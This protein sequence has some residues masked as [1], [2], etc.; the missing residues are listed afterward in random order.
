M[1]NQESATAAA[2]G[3]AA[4]HMWPVP[5]TNSRKITGGDHEASIS[6]FTIFKKARLV[7]PK[8][9][10]KFIMQLKS[11]CTSCG[12]AALTKAYTCGISKCSTR[13][14][15][16]DLCFE[17]YVRGVSGGGGIRGC[18]ARHASLLAWFRDP[19]PVSSSGSLP[20]SRQ[21]ADIS[22]WHGGTPVGNYAAD[23]PAIARGET[24]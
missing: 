15:R 21:R 18:Q 5:S 20:I 16:H 12:K 24:C 17:S 19:D 14:L 13:V 3:T 6:Q 10:H 23:L 1:V 22:G 4:A 9:H 11:N 8:L 2:V 7:I